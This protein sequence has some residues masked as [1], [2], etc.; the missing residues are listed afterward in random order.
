MI[1]VIC[2]EADVDVLTGRMSLPVGHFE[3]DGLGLR[4]L[5]DQ[6]GDGSVPPHHS[7]C[8]RQSFQ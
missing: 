2:G 8:T 4:V 5:V 1:P 3:L 7:R 6:G